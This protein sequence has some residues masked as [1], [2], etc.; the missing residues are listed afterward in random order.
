MI[1]GATRGSGGPAL[2]AYFASVG[3][4]EAIQQLEGRGLIALDPREQIAELTRMGSHARTAQ[5]LYH[6]HA[7]PPP[8][9]PWTPNERAEYWRRFEAEFGLEG[10][11]FAAVMHVKHGREHEHRVY[12]RVHASG[13]AIRL[14]H[15]HARREKLNR[16]FEFDRGEVMV[17]GAHNRAVIA[18]LEGE[19]PEVAQ[20]M[21]DAGLHEG[22]PARAA[23]MPQE[24]A[25]QSRTKVSQADVA[26]AVA[27]AW[28]H[29]DN[30]PA[31]IAALEERGLRLAAG[32][33]HPVALDSTGNTHGVTRMLAMAAKAGGTS[34]P[35]AAAVSARLD[36]LDLPSVA[37]A[38]A[39][40]APQP[41]AAPGPAD[42]DR[43]PQA[44]DHGQPLPPPTEQAA[45]AQAAQPSTSVEPS[46]TATA[47]AAATPAPAPEARATPAAAPSLPQMPAG[48]GGGSTSA[49]NAGSDTGPGASLADVG[50]GPGPPPG[51]GASPDERAK[52]LQKLQTYEERKATAWAQW[53]ATLNADAD[54]KNKVSVR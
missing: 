36:G 32:D 13:K 16:A 21:R 14:D 22:P 12:L 4:N 20:A 37:E 29:S 35:K 1:G 34:A 10:R 45:P 54:R 24:R 50:D 28:M 30:G 18:A 5:P 6:V 7:D 39:A 23:L 25:Q 3:Q 43:A 8:G 19:R 53:I 17:K 49:P 27:Q 11:P 46:A 2:G 44:P 15:D 26:A 47:P 41:Q 9:K 42:A 31:F 33:K 40:P 38:K 51:P 52:W 48:G